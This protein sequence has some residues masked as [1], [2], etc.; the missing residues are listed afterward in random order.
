MEA[1]MEEGEEAEEW[2][3]EIG[4]RKRGRGTWRRLGSRVG[5]GF[6]VLV[7]MY[8]DG[9]DTGEEV[10]DRDRVAGEGGADTMLGLEVGKKSPVWMIHFAG[11]EITIPA[12][13]SR[14]DV[15]ECEGCTYGWE[16]K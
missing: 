5:W 16:D 3:A 13:L 8:L 4:G 11:F 9:A 7:G 1:D 6:W 14:V 10:V 2:V 15:L 12:R